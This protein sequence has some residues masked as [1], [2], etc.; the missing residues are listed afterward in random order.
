VTDLNGRALYFS[1][2][3]IPFDRDKVGG[4]S[5]FKHLAFTR[6]VEWRWTASAIC[7]NRNLKR[8]SGW[9]NSAF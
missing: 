8:R 4:V 7:R 5:Y 2:S 6:T 1:R 3:T 9:S